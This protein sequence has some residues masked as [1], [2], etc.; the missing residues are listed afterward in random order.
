MS[1][2]TYR[3]L[4]AASVVL[5]MVGAVAATPAYAE[6]PAEGA[7]GDLRRSPISIAAAG[8]CTFPSQDVASTPW[9]L[10]RVLLGELWQAG[11][12]AGVA[13]GVIDTGVDNQ[14]QQLAGKV[15]DAGSS[16]KDR[17]T[18]APVEGTGVTDKVGHGTKVAGIIAARALPGRTG[19]VGIA[20]DASIVTIRQNDAEGNGDVG[21]LIDAVNT[22]IGRG[23]QVINISQ[24]VRATGENGDFD[25]KADLEA[26]L[27]KADDQGIVVV[28]SSG[29]DGH[30]GNTY[31]AAF[32]TV[33]AVGAS[34]RNNE[35]APFSQYGDFVDVVAP[36]VDMLSTVPGGGQCVDNGTSFSTPYVAG[37]AAVLMG[38]HKDWKPAQVRARIEETAQRNDRGRNKF[39]GWG[40]VDPV[41]AV[42][43]GNEQDVKPHESAK[44]QLDTVP[45]VAEPLG[46]AE[47]Q[48]DRD[49]RTG[50]FVLSAGALVVA[51]LIG[52]SVVLRDYRRRR[53]GAEL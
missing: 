39:V 43:G 47:T 49:Q 51:A 31:P 34:D 40:V 20:P 35:R 42:Q 25:R 16:L 4:A 22:M 21:S 12:G 1:L 45:I 41:K 13:V 50:T 53:P 8:E 24:D 36:G 18:G 7:G 38:M 46:L 6:P 28:A 33:L 9:A 27:K 30:E 15:T 32:D 3:R 44:V 10:Q 19:F 29:N 2:G 17:Q 37:V 26:V 11:R 14:N 23:V 5:G 52:G 48:A